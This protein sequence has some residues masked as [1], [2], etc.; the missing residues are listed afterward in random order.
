MNSQR[1]LSQ[2]DGIKAQGSG[3]LSLEDSTIQ[4]DA[5]WQ[6]ICSSGGA[7][8]QNVDG[9]QILTLFIENRDW[10][11]GFT[12]SYQQIHTSRIIQFDP[13]PNTLDVIEENIVFW[14]TPSSR[15][16][17]EASVSNVNDHNNL[18]ITSANHRQKSLEASFQGLGDLLKE[19]VQ[20]VKH[21]ATNAMKS[22]RHK[23]SSIHSLLDKL[24]ERIQKIFCGHQ[25]DHALSY[26]LTESS[27]IPSDAVSTSLDRL[28]E[29]PNP[30]K[31]ASNT[32]A[33]PD[34]TTKT[35]PPSPSRTRS[36]NISQK[37]DFPFDPAASDSFSD[38]SQLEDHRVRTL[39]L[40]I[41]LVGLF[42][43]LY[44]RLRDPRRQVD[45]AARLE[46]RRRRSLYRRAAWVQKWRNLAGRFRRQYCPIAQAVDSWDEK[47]ARVLEQESLLESV[48]EDEIRILR[49]ANRI[50]SSIDAA[51]EGR[52]DYI[53]DRGG[54]SE[55]RRSMVTLPGYE[56]EGTQPPGYES[57]VGSIIAAIRSRPIEDEDTP[58]SSIISTSPR[59]S[60]DGHDS[61]FGK[62][63]VNDWSLDSR[64]VYDFRL[65]RA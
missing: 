21:I 63:S 12:V 25:S 41:I 4:V 61:D 3:V 11:R 45:R 19:K 60:R 46:E 31:K 51:E 57:D 1:L 9:I 6:I 2:W 23:F 22:C 10:Y 37:S 29:I 7:D 49:N 59:I 15:L 43:W 34:I 44:K 40:I 62:D 14:R 24:Y 13:R 48:M 35:R 50:E 26:S 52:N 8:L 58:D 55:R 39:G 53:Y 56:S 65:Q 30:P 33:I 16:S 42:V 17:L 5:S 38:D 32:Q 27:P 54:P 18:Q 20:A 36:L 64:R 47:R 28:V